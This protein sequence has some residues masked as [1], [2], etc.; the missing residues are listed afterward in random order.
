MTLLYF[1]HIMQKSVFSLIIA[2][3]SSANGYKSLTSYN[4]FNK[5]TIITSINLFLFFHY[6]QY[7]P[8]SSNNLNV[9]LKKNLSWGMDV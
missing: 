1:T 3:K 2:K 9:Y 4:T 5:F 8:F 7:K 6:L